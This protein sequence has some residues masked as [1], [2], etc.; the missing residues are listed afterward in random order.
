MVD[1]EGAVRNSKSLSLYTASQF[2]LKEEC[3][4]EHPVIT[5]DNDIKLLEPLGSK[6]T[7]FEFENGKI[8]FEKIHGLKPDYATD[9]RIWTCLTHSIFWEY[10]QKRVPKQ[11]KTING[12][13]THWFQVSSHPKYL[14]RNDI[15][16]LWWITYLTYDGKRGD[17]YELTRLAFRDQDQ[18]RTIYEG[19]Q[20]RN[21]R[22]IQA[23]LEFENS[24]PELF[25]HGREDK[26]RELMKKLNYFGSYKVLSSMSDDQLRLLL[27]GC[28]DFLSKIK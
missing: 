8:L 23:I 13:L 7:Q 28:R 11:D 1:L 25:E 5:I 16:R 27:D 22:M 19:Y 4:W 15:S 26:Y 21:R 18:T 3:L 20:G 9:P 14:M 12:V 6:T 17:P 10:M 24:N 2:P